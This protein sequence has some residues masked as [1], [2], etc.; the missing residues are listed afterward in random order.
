MDMLVK[1][2]W[3]DKKDEMW[4][5]QKTSLNP[6]WSQMDSVGG[7]ENDPN[8]SVLQDKSKGVDRPQTASESRLHKLINLEFMHIPAAIWA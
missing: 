8:A 3:G 6:K 4:L 7:S 5:Q 2:L 1:Y